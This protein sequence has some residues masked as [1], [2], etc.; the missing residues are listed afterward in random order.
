MK[1]IFKK[2]II[3]LS[4]LGVTGVAGSLHGQISADAAEVTMQ[5]GMPKVL[6]HTWYSHYRKG[7]E[8]YY[9]R[10][11]KIT[12]KQTSFQDKA[13]SK[14]NGKYILYAQGSQYDQLVDLTYFESFNKRNFT[15]F[16]SSKESYAAPRYTTVKPV[17]TF[18]LSKN[19]KK[20]VLTAYELMKTVRGDHDV[21]SNPS[22]SVTFYR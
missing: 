1:K 3:A 21:I 11:M 5:R 8:Y 20:V 22:L 10:E 7:G 13:Y 15:V 19:R 16:S 2:I 4:M 6:R 12:N 9:R 14:T 17:L 18:D